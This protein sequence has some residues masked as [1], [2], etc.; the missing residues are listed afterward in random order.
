MKSSLRERLGPRVQVKAIVHAQSGSPVRFSF[1]RTSEA[2][3]T[4]EAAVSLAR[5]RMPMAQAHRL[6]TKL[7]QLETGAIIVAEVPMVDDVDGL[8]AELA[9]FGIAS[10][11]FDVPAV[12]DTRTVRER[13]GLSQAKFALNYALD[14]DTVK[15]WEQGRTSPDHAARA[16]LSMIATDPDG[17]RLLL[18]KAIWK[19]K[20]RELSIA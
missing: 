14:E 17:V 10:T 6:M 15:N 12:V 2:P 3:N 4:P 9:E 16:Y 5:C 20:E 11:V 18:A 13:T 1:V 8:M 7:L 19:P